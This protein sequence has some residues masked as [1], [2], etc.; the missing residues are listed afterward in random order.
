MT[1]LAIA[2]LSGSDAARMVMTKTM[3]LLPDGGEAEVRI[4]DSWL[5][6]EASH[7]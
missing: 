3:R 1:A 2:R 5:D 6:L 7:E 4:A